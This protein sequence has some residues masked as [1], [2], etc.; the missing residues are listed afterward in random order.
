MAA[1]S[2]CKYDKAE[3]QMVNR[4][5]SRSLVPPQSAESLLIN[6]YDAM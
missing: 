4:A 3:E 1:I 5:V 6:V 2:S